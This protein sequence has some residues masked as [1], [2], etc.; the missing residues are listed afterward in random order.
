MEIKVKGLQNA[1]DLERTLLNGADWFC[2]NQ[3]LDANDRKRVN[4]RTN[5]GEC[6]ICGWETVAYT[7]DG[8]EHTRYTCG[9]DIQTPEQRVRGSA[10][11]VLLTGEDAKQYQAEQRAEEVKRLQPLANRA[12]DIAMEQLA[13]AYRV[14]LRDEEG[15]LQLLG[16]N[17]RALAEEALEALCSL[18]S[19]TP[20]GPTSGAFDE[21]LNAAL[22]FFAGK[23]EADLE[24]GEERITRSPSGVLYLDGVPVC[25]FDGFEYEDNG[26]TG[27]FADSAEERTVTKLVREI[28]GI[29]DEYEDN[30]PVIV[31][32]RKWRD[33][34][35]VFVRVY[36]SG[37]TFVSYN[38]GESLAGGLY[39][40]LDHALGAYGPNDWISRCLESADRALSGNAS[41]AE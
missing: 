36:A 4:S 18:M 22:A 11:F 31:W 8:D 13:D 2:I 19:D 17:L 38:S 21:A 27:G 20:E 41:E 40:T 23:L 25:W 7:V 32:Q 33:S 16:E 35:G 29:E 5:H 30:G 1:K 28:A 39:E 37:K 14:F 3:I 12:V 26:V 6:G 15:D 9:C 10:W 34:S 24:E